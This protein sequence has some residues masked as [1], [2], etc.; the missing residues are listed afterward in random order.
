MFKTAVAKCES[1]A[2]ARSNEASL[3]DIEQ[4]NSLDLQQ[5]SAMIKTLNSNTSLTSIAKMFRDTFERG[6]SLGISVESFLRCAEQHQF[7]SSSL[8]LPSY[9]GAASSTIEDCDLSANQVDEMRD[10]VYRHFHLFRDTLR[11]FQER[12]GPI[13]ARGLQRLISEFCNELGLHSASGGG[14]VGVDG[15]RLLCAYR[16]VLDFLSTSRVEMLEDV[17]EPSDDLMTKRLDLELEHTEQLLCRYLQG[18]NVKNEVSLNEQLVR[19][20]RRVAAARIKEQWRVRMRD[21]PMTLKMRRLM[22]NDYVCFLSL[23]LSPP[24]TPIPAPTHKTN[25]KTGTRNKRTFSS[26][27]ISSSSTKRTMD[28]HVDLQCCR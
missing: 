11:E 25:S 18:S 10:V 21:H 17:G 26:I 24:S 9:Y 19:I 27:S 20:M 6:S 15:R 23:S 28:G 8:R 16:R 5:F 12:L 2:I 1:N 22:S 14:I 3:D 13:Q 4:T 7:F